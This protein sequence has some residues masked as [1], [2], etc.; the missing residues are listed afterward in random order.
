LSLIVRL[1]R[2]EAFQVAKWRPVF[3]GSHYVIPSVFEFSLHH[4]RG[5]LIMAG[6]SAENW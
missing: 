6:R 1:R 3:C 2:G 5:M 4:N